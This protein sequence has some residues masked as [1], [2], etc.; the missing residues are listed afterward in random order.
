MEFLKIEKNLRSFAFQTTNLWKN[1]GFILIGLRHSVSVSATV[2]VGLPNGAT[3][4]ASFPLFYHCRKEHEKYNTCKDHHTKDGPGFRSADNK[5][6][7]T[8]IWG[9]GFFH[10]FFEY[11]L[12]RETLLPTDLIY[13]LGHHMASSIWLYSLLLSLMCRH[14]RFLWNSYTHKRC[15]PDIHAAVSD[16]FLET[17]RSFLQLAM[18]CQKL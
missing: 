17:W 13:Y 7:G 9:K 2:P 4:Q 12:Q 14:Q 16:I 6:R 1:S 15:T 11:F 3:I 10:V 8:F 5:V 18:D